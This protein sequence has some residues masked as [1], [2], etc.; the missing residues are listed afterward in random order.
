MRSTLEELLHRVNI[1][2]VISQHV[3]LRKSGKDFS[4]LCPFHSEKTPSFT[5]SIE[6]QIYYCFGC[7]EGGNVINFLMKFENMTFQE[8]LENLA[9]EYGVEIKKGGTKRSNSFDAMSKLADYYHNNIKN[10]RVAL[11]YLSRRGITS[12]VIDEFKIGYSDRSRNSIRTFIK[13]SGIPRDVLLN[14]GILRLKDTEI[15]DMFMG[16]VVVPIIDVNKKVI[17]F[18]GRTI[19]KEGFPKYINSPE[20][21]IFSKGTSL[22]GIDKTRK[23][24]TEKNEVFIVEGYFDFIAL[25]TAG[26]KNIV[27]TLGTSVTEEQLI[28]L[29]NYTDNITLMLDGDEAGIKSALK[30][31]GRL[32][33]MDINGS[34][35]VLPD[36]HD[37]DSF[38]KKEGMDALNKLINTK[39]PIMDYYFDYCMA[40]WGV[41]TME[42]KNRFIKS[43]LPYIEGIRGGVKKRLYIKRL[44]ELTGVEEYHF[45]E[46][47][48]ERR[49]EQLSGNYISSSIIERKV[50]G[51]LMGKPG[52]L[53]ILKEKE[54]INYIKDAEIK[55]ILMNMCD[56]FDE[57]GTME[58]NNFINVL[59]TDSLRDL[60]TNAVFDVA[61]YEDNELEKVL[62]DYFRHV[63]KNSIK[64]KAK[65]ITERL[66][67]AEKRGDE[68]EIMELLNEK[69]KVLAFFK[70][71][72]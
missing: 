42:N 6:K 65:K 72:Q 67:E 64:D 2:D 12:D 23:H 41:G 69:R 22:F 30:L 31:I 4:G 19:E 39:K 56:F 60:V 54:V 52:M 58:V 34:M 48:E 70:T 44:S 16:R 14:T 9:H 25:Y 47:L 28:R 32:S 36:G 71:N 8:T 59:G 24:I 53:G 10:N 27:S 68:K 20:S 5:V 1:V 33:D 40:K 50:I 63:E 43:V 38:I 62:Q 11:E 51:A 45:R 21:P 61:G 13:N 57:K 49:T 18:G 46:G 3:K 17:G 15:Y 7:H 55:E 26:L 66:L 29:R 35:V 37:P